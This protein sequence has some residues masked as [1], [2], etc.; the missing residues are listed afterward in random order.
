M[1]TVLILIF[2]FLCADA[3]AQLRHPVTTDWRSGY[4]VGTYGRYQVATNAPSTELVWNIYQGKFLDRNSRE[5]VSNRL[6]NI[7]G[8]G[9]DLDYGIYARHLPDSGNGLGWYINLAD[10]THAHGRYT[11]D[12]LNLVMFG[13]AAY[14]GETADLSNLYATFFS[15]KQFEA[16]LLKQVATNAGTWNIGFGLSFLAGNRNLE[17]TIDEGS[18]YTDPDGQ[19]LDGTLAGSI[20]TSSLGSSQFI[21]GNGLGMSAALSVAFETKKFGLSIEM[22]DVGFLLWSKN[23]THTEL[24]STFRFEGVDINLFGSGGDSFTN[25]SVDSLFDGLITEV[26][27]EPYLRA[28]PGRIR[29]EG[30]YRVNEKDLRIYAGI[31]HRIARGYVPYGYVGV[32]SPLPKGFFIDGRFA[33]G[34]FGSWHLG[35]EVRKSFKEAFEV[36]IGT[37]NLEGYVLPMFGTSQS[38]YI[39]LAGYF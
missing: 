3:M 7:N 38:A 11:R 37:N 35:L 33:Y 12:L 18:L 17:L 16:G 21:D 32:S 26:E 39:S 8:I 30:F 1:R 5:S 31:E 27:A 14:A 9:V 4:S 13:N 22:D 15:Y 25:L 23:L 6:Q 29:L 24:D 2:W 10:R 19:Y 20:R 28:I 34:G 36:R